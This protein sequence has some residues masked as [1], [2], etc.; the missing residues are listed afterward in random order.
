[1]ALDLAP[2]HIRVNCVA[3]GYVR[4]DLVQTLLDEGKLDSAALLRRIPMGEFGEGTDVAA[5][6]SWLAGSESR[7]VTGE[8]LV[9]DGGWAAYGHV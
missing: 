9:V 2:H 3:P 4:T 8:T 5:A 6:V 7:Y 1:M